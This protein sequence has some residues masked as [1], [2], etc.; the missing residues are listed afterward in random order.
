MRA[1]VCKVPFDRGYEAEHLAASTNVLAIV[2]AAS[3]QVLEDIAP[4]APLYNAMHTDGMHEL[5]THEGIML[6]QYLM[7]LAL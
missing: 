7:T 5:C 1:C 4:T 3:A 6:G 2:L